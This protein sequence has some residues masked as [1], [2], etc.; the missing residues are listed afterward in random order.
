MTDF[1]LCSA[2]R[3]RSQAGFCHCT[4]K[5][6]FRPALA[7][8]RTPPLLFRRR[9]PQSNYPPYNVLAPE[10]WSV[11]RCQEHKGWYL[12]DDSTQ[13]GARASKSPTY[14]A[15]RIPNTNRGNRYAIRAGRNLPDKEFRYLR[16]VSFTAAVYW[17]FNSELSP[18]ILTFQHRAGVR[19]YTST[20]VFAEPCVFSKQS[21]PPALCHPQMVAH[22]DGDL[23]SFPFHHGLSTRS[24]SAVEQLT[25]IRS[26]IG[27]GKRMSLPS[28]FSALPPATYSTTLYLNRFRG[29]PAISKFDWPFTPSHSS[30][31]TIATVTVVAVLED[32]VLIPSKED[33]YMYYKVY[34]PEV[35]GE[36]TPL[37]CVHGMAGN[38]ACFDYL[39]RAVPDFPV[40]SVDVV[41]RG[42]SSWLKDYSLY[43]Y[44]TYC[45]DILHLA[46]HLKIK[47]CNYLGISMGG[48]IA[49]FLAAHFHNVL[50]IEKL[51]IND[52]GPYTPAKPLRALVKVM[53]E[54]PTFEDQEQAKQYLKAALPLRTEKEEHWITWCTQ[55]YGE[56][57]ATC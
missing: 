14:P 54:L 12:K 39:G 3:P 27:F 7:Y 4:I 40:V 37:I 24:V 31:N 15:H 45:A 16:T 11:V 8:H 53:T 6:D 19:P 32:R 9:P 20:Y 2:R 43:N 42:R 17:G 46:K 23:G 26:L 25:G 22:P 47:K 30:S 44:S 33:H 35:L 1:R 52:I 13:A 57:A 56:G 51:I 38:S 21:L 29:E 49:M 48:I 41:G 55:N 34:N 28:P 50:A 5:A 18:L 10:K 36:K